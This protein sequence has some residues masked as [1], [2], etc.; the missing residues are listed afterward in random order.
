ME[1]EV[2]LY[3]GSNKIIEKPI[4]GFGKETNDFGLGFYLTTDEELGKEWSAYSLNE[5]SFLNKYSLSLNNLKILDLTTSNYSIFNWL[6]LLLKFRYFNYENNLERKSKKYFID[7]YYIDISSFDLILGFRADD[8][9]FDI[10]Q[11]FLRGVISTRQLEF[12]LKAGKLGK[13][14]VLKSKKAFDNLNFINY[15]IIDTKTYYYKRKERDNNAKYYYENVVLTLPIKKKDKTIRDI[16][17]K[18]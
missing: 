8:S 10:I 15:E 7:N 16:V 3:H 2:I 14:I 17:L 18:D 4:F 11:D 6:A 1:K 9:Y 5:K 13:Q 12:A